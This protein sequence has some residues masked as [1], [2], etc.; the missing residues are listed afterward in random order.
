MTVEQLFADA[1][2]RKKERGPKVFTVE[3][4]EQL[5]KLRIGLTEYESKHMYKQDSLDAGEVIL[6]LWV[7]NK[8]IV[9]QAMKEQHEKLKELK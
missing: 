6:P 8:A 1:E 4:K 3:E 5:R 9:R 7:V 2:R